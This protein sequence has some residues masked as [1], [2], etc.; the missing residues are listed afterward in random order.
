LVQVINLL[1]GLICTPP[2]LAL[3]GKF[4]SPLRADFQ[5]FI[6]LGN[7]RKRQNQSLTEDLDDLF[8]DCPSVTKKQI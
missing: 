7:S 2:S 5:K 1:N 6:S 3:E 8:E 4:D